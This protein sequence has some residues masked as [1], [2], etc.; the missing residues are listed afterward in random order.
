V[1]GFSGRQD[2]KFS[3]P[4]QL[5]SPEGERASVRFIIDADRR[6][7]IVNFGESLTVADIRRYVQDLRSHPGFDSS[8]SEIAD[9]SKV[10]DLPLEIW[11][12]LTL[13]DHTDPFSLESKRAFV[14]QTPLQEHAA[15]MHKTLRNQR[16]FEIF[17]TLKEAE[18]W[19]TSKS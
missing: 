16:N 7:V 10:K 11:D 4:S 12:F 9:I 6:L 2:P 17:R 3:R 5:R 19:I 8:F 14:V 18:D 13:A 15:G 1:K